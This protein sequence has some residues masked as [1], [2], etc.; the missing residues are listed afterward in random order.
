MFSIIREPTRLLLSYGPDNIS[1]IKRR[2]DD[3]DVIS[4]NRTFHFKRTDC[5]EATSRDFLEAAFDDLFAEKFAFRDLRFVLGDITNG[6]YRIKKEILELKF[7]L[8]IST[9][10]EKLDKSSFVAKN[11]VSIFSRIDRLTSE[12]IVIGGSI[13]NAIP[14]K[15][16]KLLL[17]TFPTDTELRKYA[18]SRISGILR[19]Y[20][21]S[22]TDAQRNLTRYLLKK[23]PVRA[24]P[25]LASISEYEAQKYRFIHDR[26]RE[27]LADPDAFSEH[28]WQDKI[29]DFILII[30]PKYI[31]SFKSVRIND[32]YTDSK[33]V[34]HR[35]ID[36]AIVD[37][38]GHMDIIEIKKPFAQ[39]VLSTSTYRDNFVPKKELSGAVVQVEKYL[40]HLAKWGVEGERKLTET[41]HDSLPDGLTLKIINPKAMIILGRSDAFSAIQAFDF[42]IIRRKYAN[43]VDILTYDDLL[44]RLNNIIS[45]FETAPNRTPP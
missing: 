38:N 33:H 41:Y 10:I 8:L 5:D 4:I 32:Y 7:D 17:T 29:L 2:L 42:E 27:M 13:E 28:D 20:L 30:Y 1:W 18:D 19:E 16:F 22:M 25:E 40:F 21:G 9:E 35:Y 37:T 45:K 26:I 15:D 14:L 12:P 6:Y 44:Q 3:D 11:N 24:R 39:C 34:T 23:Q 43:I 31:R 36:I